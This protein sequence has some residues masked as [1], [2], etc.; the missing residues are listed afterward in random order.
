MK[1]LLKNSRGMSL[2]EVMI[3]ITVLALLAVP[4]MISFMNTQVIA[5]KVDK[6]TEISAITRTVKQIVSD[7]LIDNQ[8]MI[9]VDDTVLVDINGD[10]NPDTFQDFVSYAVTQAAPVTSNELQIMETG[11]LNSK[12]KYKITCGSGADY[13]D[14]AI[15]GV[16]NVVITI[17]EKDSGKIANKLK[18]AVSIRKTT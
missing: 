7:G 16:Y 17:M 4:L 10:S 18:I 11:R 3:A 2:V 8:P 5:R 13:Y 1:R 12:Y 14:P 6:Q 9:D 15:S